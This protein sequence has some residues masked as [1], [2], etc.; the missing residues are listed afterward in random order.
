M[1]VNPACTA[2]PSARRLCA[3]VWR[4]PRRARLSSRAV[5]MPSERRFTPARR[6]AANRSGVTVS[7]LASSVISAPGRRP[8]GAD[9]TGRLRGRQQRGRAAAEIERVG[10]AAAWSRK[11]K[12]GPFP[13]TGVNVRLGYTVRAWGG[14]EVAVTAF[15]T[16]IG[17]M[18]V[19]AKH[20]TPH[21]TFITLTLSGIEIKVNL[22]CAFA[23]GL[24]R[25]GTRYLRRE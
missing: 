17:D 11:A 1:S 3:A 19:K 7:G 6:N 24:K 20:I 10:G 9:E 13:G 16:A 23:T 4:R 22:E 14:I 12:N 15:G 8:G 25:G 18:D 21:W 2:I 5:C